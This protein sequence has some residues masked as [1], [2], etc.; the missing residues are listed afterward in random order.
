MKEKCTWGQ[1]A[2]Y[3]AWLHTHFPTH[4]EHVWRYLNTLYPQWRYPFTFCWESGYGIMSEKLLAAYKDPTQA[5]SLGGVAEFAK[6][7]GLS[8]AKVKQL[9]QQELS[10]TLYKPR[11]KHFPTLPVLVFDIDQQWVMD[12]VDLQKLAHWNQGN[13]YLLTVVGVLSKYTWAIPIKSKSGSQMVTALETL[14]KQAAPRK[15]QQVQ[16]D[17]KPGSIT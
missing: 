12:L 2:V 15:P 8:K 1:Y 9:L 14:C 7:H 13:K 10:Y 16:K 4:G 17:A 11:R 5:G 3:I 6:A